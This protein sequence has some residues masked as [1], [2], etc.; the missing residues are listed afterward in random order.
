MIMEDKL[1]DRLA[2]EIEDKALWK[3]LATERMR[4]INQCMLDSDMATADINSLKAERDLL[5]AERDKLRIACATAEHEKQEALIKLHNLVNAAVD[6]IPFISKRAGDRKVKLV[7][8]TTESL[9][10]YGKER[11]F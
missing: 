7:V 1:L 9:D 5:A 6:V 11:L 8:E 10:W 2:K 4:I 3:S